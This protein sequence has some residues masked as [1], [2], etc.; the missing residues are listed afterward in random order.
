MN[1]LI[2]VGQAEG[3]FVM[4]LGSLLFE[5]TIYDPLTGKCLRFFLNNYFFYK[6]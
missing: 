6:L 2:D 4:G 3:A 1:G 5:K